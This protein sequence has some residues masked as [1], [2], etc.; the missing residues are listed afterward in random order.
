VGHGFAIEIE[1]RGLGMSDEKLAEANG[2]LAEPLPFDPANTDQLGLLV[3]GQ[4]ARRHDIQITL[5]GNPYG[6]TTAIVLIPHTIVVAEGL[7]ELEPVKALE[8]APDGA[9]PLPGG[10]DTGEQ[11]GLAAGEDTEPDLAHEGKSGERGEPAGMGGQEPGLP[12][13]HAAPPA[14]PA[15][16]A[17]PTP[18]P[19]AP[20][21]PAPAVPA[22]A[23]PTAAVPSWAATGQDS[24]DRDGTGQPV[25]P[26]RVRQA[27]LVPQLRNPPPAYPP[28]PGRYGDQRPPDEAR[29]TVSA[30]QH[31]WERGKSMF[32][33]AAGP[34]APE[35][36]E[37]GTAHDE[38]GTF[39]GYQQETPAEDRGPDGPG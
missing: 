38:G 5:R 19:P 14:P 24:T 20:A 26:R 1:D 23:P 16:L 37:S 33:P 34:A 11:N 25:L 18:P 22:P 29:A 6:G 21:P 31:G 15:P 39:G 9:P 30:I 7:G 28:L 35:A 3:A 12:S 2:Q 13:Y 4:L 17:P 8:S 36:G 10:H 32:D 27:S